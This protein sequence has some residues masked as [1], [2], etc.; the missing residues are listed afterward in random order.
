MAAPSIHD[1]D[2]ENQFQYK[3][4]P[5]PNQE[6]E[7]VR[8]KRMIRIAAPGL[9]AALTLLLA[10]ALAAPAQAWSRDSTYACDEDEDRGVLCRGLRPDGS[11]T[12]GVPVAV[13]DG[14][15][16][17][18][19]SGRMDHNGEY[20]FARP[21]GDFRVTFRPDEDHPRTL[22]GVGCI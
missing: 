19:A 13:V 14:G 15:G 20:S 6:K 10:L 9:M 11:P 1:N 7:A 2:V 17:L 22:G 5:W 12:S 16:E 18:L 21:E 3:L 4:W 8:M